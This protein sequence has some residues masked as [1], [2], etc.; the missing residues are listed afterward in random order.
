MK[1]LKKKQQ[2]PYYVNLSPTLCLPQLT[3]KYEHWVAS[4]LAL[5]SSS[6]RQ[7]ERDLWKAFS[8]FTIWVLSTRPD[9]TPCIHSPFISCPGVGPQPDSACHIITETSDVLL[10]KHASDRVLSGS[11][12]SGS[13]REM[14]SWWS[15][16]IHLQR[17][18]LSLTCSC[19][20]SVH[21][22]MCAFVCLYR[23]RTSGQCCITLHGIYSS[24]RQASATNNLF[25]SGCMLGLALLAWESCVI[26]QLCGFFW[27]SRLIYGSH[28]LCSLSEGPC[29]KPRRLQSSRQGIRLQSPHTHFWLAAAH[30]Q[31]PCFCGDEIL[32]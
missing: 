20:Y 28:P 27:Q 1:T 7:I 3:F 26:W 23:C 31:F 11:L 10:S 9:K 32:L 12:W 22:T 4:A 2:Q 21:V 14:I 17:L 30:F 19:M 24:Y 5:S 18:G 29:Y 8:F 15:W 25:L 16:Q 6:D 13:S